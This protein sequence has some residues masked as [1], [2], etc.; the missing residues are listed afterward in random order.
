MKSKLCN[1]AQ[2]QLPSGIYY[3]PE[4]ANKEVLGDVSP[5]NDLCESI[6]GLNDYLNS[7]LPNMHQVT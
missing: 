3:N 6:L 5:S 4:S 1:Y 7:A 2:H